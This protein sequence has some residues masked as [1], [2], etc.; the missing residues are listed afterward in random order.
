MSNPL[1]D[2]QLRHTALTLLEKELGPVETLRF[3]AMVRR[4]PF[5]YQAWRDDRF[6]GLTVEDLFRRMQAAEVAS[7]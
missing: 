4:E 6:A 1:T 7:P 5:D 2:D 3:L